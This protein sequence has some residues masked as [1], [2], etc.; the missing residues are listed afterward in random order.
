MASG[1]A[2]V[3]LH[4]GEGQRGGVPAPHGRDFGGGRAGAR[5]GRWGP[6]FDKLRAGSAPTSGRLWR[7]LELTVRVVVRIKDRD[8]RE[9]VLS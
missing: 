7:R 1:G 3:T 6:P 9:Y 4:L 2:W 5:L 8:W